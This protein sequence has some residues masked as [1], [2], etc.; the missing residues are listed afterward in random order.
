MH[1]GGLELALVFLLAAV[2]A[3]PVFRRFGLGAVLGGRIVLRH[4]FRMVARTQMPEVFTGAALLTVLGAAWIMQGAGLSAGLGAFLAGVLL[5]DSEFRHEL[6][7]QKFARGVRGAIS[8]IEAGALAGTGM[9]EIGAL[10]FCSTRG[11][12]T[13]SKTSSASAGSAVRCREV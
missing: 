2:I 1:G 4:V 9:N 10:E 3:V 5:A 7:A 13:Q 8:A 12:T 6:E 11:E